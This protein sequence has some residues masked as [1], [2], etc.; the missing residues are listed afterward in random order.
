METDEEADGADGMRESVV[1]RS[2]EEE[3]RRVK[4]SIWDTAGQERFRV[5]TGSYYRGAMGV[6]LGE[7]SL[8]PS[9]LVT[10]I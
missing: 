2:G 3:G 6:V 7:S 5:L 4:L 10:G 1:Q 9:L 8:S